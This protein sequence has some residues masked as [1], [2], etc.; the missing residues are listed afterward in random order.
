MSWIIPATEYPTQCFRK[1]DRRQLRSCKLL[2]R[3]LGRYIGFLPKINGG[4]S[5][6]PLSP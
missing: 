6:H 1:L 3:G 2:V 4:N 5:A